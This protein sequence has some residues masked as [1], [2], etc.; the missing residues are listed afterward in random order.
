MDLSVPARILTAS[1]AFGGDQMAK[2][3]SALPCGCPVAA[4][5]KMI[6]GKYKL[7]IV[8]DLKDG[9]RAMAKSEPACCAAPLA[10]P[11]LRRA[12]LAAS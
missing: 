3:K 10:V 9:P 7:R 5:Q 6:S 11:K 4:F 1:N 8:W 2:P 12:C